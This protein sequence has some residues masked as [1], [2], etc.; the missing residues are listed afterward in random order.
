M[1]RTK[2]KTAAKRGWLKA[3]ALKAGVREQYAR[4]VKGTTF[5]VELWWHPRHGYVVTS[6]ILPPEEG[7]ITTGDEWRFA[8]RLPDAR[9]RFT[10]AVNE[11]P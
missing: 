1:P 2:S 5:V 8:E 11:L 6:Q 9:E 4:I 3:D 10:L 7:R